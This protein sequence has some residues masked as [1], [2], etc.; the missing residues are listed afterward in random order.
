VNWTELGQG[1][2]SN[3]LWN[4]LVEHLGSITR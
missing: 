3:W 4:Q 2:V 1:H